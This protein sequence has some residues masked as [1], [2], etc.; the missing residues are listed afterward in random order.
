MLLAEIKSW[1]AR[2]AQETSWTSILLPHPNLFSWSQ[3]VGLRL[4]RAGRSFLGCTFGHHFG[5]SLDALEAAPR[6]GRE[7]RGTVHHNCKHTCQ[8]RKASSL[9]LFFFPKKPRVSPEKPPGFSFEQT[10]CNFPPTTPA[11]RQTAATARSAPP[12]RAR[13]P[14]SGAASPGRSAWRRAPGSPNAAPGPWPR[15]APPPEPERRGAEG[16]KARRRE[17]EKGRGVF[18]WGS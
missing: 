6:L 5:W 1:R 13:G 7:R 17:G 15:S 9:L 10:P 14:G 2:L 16:E 18:F 12:R 8:P 3:P 11:P 4:A